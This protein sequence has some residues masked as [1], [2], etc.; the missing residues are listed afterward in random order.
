M[1]FDIT[2]MLAYINQNAKPIATKVVTEPKTMKLLSTYGALQFG[3]GKDA[4]TT[5]S[6]S[7]TFSDGK[8]C[9]IVEDSATVFSERQILFVP[10]KINKKYCIKELYSTVLNTAI[11]KGQSNETMDSTIWNAVA[12][13]IANVASYE[14]EKLLW[15]GDST[16]T[17]TNNLKWFDGYVKLI[18]TDGATLTLAGSDLIAKLQSAVSQIDITLRSQEDFRIFM[19]EDTKAALDLVLY[20]KNLYNP[21]ATVV[22]PGTTVKIEVV[23][24]MNG[25]NKIIATRV[26]NLRAIVDETG[27]ETKAEMIVDPLT[28]NSYINFYFGGGV[29][30]VFP[31]QSYYATLA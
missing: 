22:V 3:K 10:L 21:G 25:T 1:S 24:G 12:E 5:M 15:K 14:Y 2:G 7:V 11:S 30:V 9:A 31:S 13:D 18:T 26:S 16:L 19:G 27:E 23:S 8:S 6:N 29:Q 20:N 17:G 28:K 4:V